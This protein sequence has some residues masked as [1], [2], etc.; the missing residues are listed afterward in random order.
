MSNNTLVIKPLEYKLNTT[1]TTNTT[2]KTNKTNYICEISVNN[3]IV[4][5]EFGQ[6]A[7]LDLNNFKNNDKNIVLTIIN[8][9]KNKNKNNK[10]IID[11]N[12]YKDLL[13]KFAK[14]SWHKLTNNN[15]NIHSIKLLI[16]MKNITNII[17]TNSFNLTNYNTNNLTNTLE[18]IITESTILVDEYSESAQRSLNLMIQIEELGAQ[19]LNTLETQGKKLNS[20]KTTNKNIDDDISIA[21]YELRSI[22]SIGGHI[23]NMIRGKPKPKPKNKNETKTNSKPEIK[24]TSP[25]ITTTNINNNMMREMLKNGEFDHLSKSTQEQIQ[26]TE[27]KLDDI[28]K[29]IHSVG[30]IAKNINNELIKQNELLTE[31]IPAIERS[32]NNVKK[33]DNKTKRQF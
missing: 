13:I 11:V 18:D 20:V 14:P 7:E 22:S 24:V 19:T 4:Q 17:S 30:S 2:N 10:I 6:I 29:V 21:N 12:S 23:G 32:T 8:Q 9:K 31:L 27:N 5:V 28:T 26:S 16:G 15:D 33:A 1:N 3:I 25:I